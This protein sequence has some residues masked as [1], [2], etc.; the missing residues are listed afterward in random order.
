[1]LLSL[2]T[3]LIPLSWSRGRYTNMKETVLGTFHR[4]EVGCDDEHRNVQFL[5]R[6]A[7]EIVERGIKLYVNVMPEYC[8]EET[9]RRILDVKDRHGI[10]VG[11]TSL[12]HFYD[13]KPITNDTTVPCQKRVKD[14]LIDCNGNAFFCYKQ[15]M[16]NPVFNLF[17]VTKEE[18]EYFLEQHDPQR[19]Q[20]CGCCPKY[21]PES[22]KSKF[23]GSIS[24]QFIKMCNE[25]PLSK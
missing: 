18:L 20:F 21:M 19:Y 8:S 22:P 13:S 25:I 12:H 23:V 14:L 6:F 11:F 2:G 4:L 3:N 5:E 1:M 15:E 10:Q 17:E 24:K 16:E 7:P 9:K